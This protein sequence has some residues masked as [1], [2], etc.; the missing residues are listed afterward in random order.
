MAS[1]LKIYWLVLMVMIINVQLFAQQKWKNV[2]SEF[3]LSTQNFHLFKSTDSLDE[4]PFV[5][6][7]ITANLKDKNL[8]FTTDTTY[9]R[10]FTPEQ[11]Y[12]KNN[13]P[14]LVVNATFF[15]FQ[16]NQNLNV[17]IQNKKILSYNL[18][19]IAGK[20]KDTFTYLHPFTSAI[21]I[22]KRRNADV[23][24]VLTDSAQQNVF[25]TQTTLGVPKKDSINNPSFNYLNANPRYR[26]WRCAYSRKPKKTLFKKWNMQT[27]VGGGPVLIQDGQIKIYNNEELKFVGNE[28]NDKHPRT[29]MG[30][31]NDG[32]LI[33]LVVQGRTPNI[34]DGV[35]LK[36]A[37]KL[38]QDIGCVE[39]LNLDGGGSTCMLINGKAVFKPSDAAGQRAIPA[40]FIINKN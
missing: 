1:L 20:A 25:A 10:R 2:D 23:A 9:N 6:F 29:C 30:Y 13:Q 28:I 19:T 31:T 5:A 34:S 8:I 32:Q 21:G 16:K 36:Q 18:H 15:N 3:S 27:A 39:A 38:L 40:V 11:F 24:W 26:M 22:D 17:V 33:I 7:Y 37:A 4:K 14:L 12:Q 35:T